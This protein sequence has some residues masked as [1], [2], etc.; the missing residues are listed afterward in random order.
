MIS[1]QSIQKAVTEHPLSMADA[2]RSLDVPF[3]TF[4]YWAKKHE[5]YSPN[6]NHKGRTFENRKGATPLKE[7]IYEGLH[8]DYRTFRLRQRLVRAGIL[9]NI[10]DECGITDE[11]NGKPITLELDHIDGDNRNHHIENLRILC[12]NCHSQTPTFRGRNHK[13]K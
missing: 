3:A 8:P 5:L 1:K 13:H 7:I 2:A 9:K 4:K 10:C 12:P 6:Q 11:W